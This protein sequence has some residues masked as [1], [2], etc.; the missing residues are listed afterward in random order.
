VFAAASEQL[1]ATKETT[2][3]LSRALVLIEEMKTRWKVLL[4]SELQRLDVLPHSRIFNFS[5]FYSFC[6]ISVSQYMRDL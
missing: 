6:V 1:K 5:S 2:A 3:R 4:E